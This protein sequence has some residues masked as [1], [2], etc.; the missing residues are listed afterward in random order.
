MAP[1]IVRPEHSADELR[2]TVRR[3]KDRRG[4]ESSNIDTLDRARDGRSVKLQCD[5]RRRRQAVVGSF[6]W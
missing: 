2:D 4:G 6:K 1:A 3:T 5:G